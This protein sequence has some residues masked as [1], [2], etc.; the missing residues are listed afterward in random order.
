ME[1]ILRVTEICQKLEALLSARQAVEEKLDVAVD[2]LSRIF[3]VQ[4]NEVA[5][6][7]L[8]QAQDSLSFLWPKEMRSSGSIPFSANR[9]LVAVT[10]Q[11]R[12]ST[13]NNTFAST[14]HLFVFEAFGKARSAPIQKIMSVPMLNGDDLRGVIQVSRKGEDTDISLRNFSESEL[15]ALSEM[16]KVIGRHL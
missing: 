8:D 1:A 12:R 3:G 11:Q 2:A 13:L 6:F 10:A 4:A 14:P 5:V 16:A 9:S 7:S 15:T